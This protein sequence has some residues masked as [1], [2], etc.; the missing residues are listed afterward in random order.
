MIAGQIVSLV[1][2]FLAI[3]AAGV[4]LYVCLCMRMHKRRVPEPPYITYF[5][6]FAH[7][8]ICFLLLLTASLWG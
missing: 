1:V 6:L 5:F 2:V 4:A 3:P 8:G 7:G